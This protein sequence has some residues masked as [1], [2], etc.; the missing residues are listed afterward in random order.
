M[1][2]RL[3]RNAIAWVS[4]SSASPPPAASSSSATNRAIA[5]EL[6]T[7]PAA[8][9]PMPSAITSRCGPAYPESWLLLY[10]PRPMSDRAA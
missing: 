8:W 1:Q 4:R 9:P 6:A 10:R 7:S 2:V 3:R 5:V